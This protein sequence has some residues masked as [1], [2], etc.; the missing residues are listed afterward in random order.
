MDEQ[1]PTPS[2]PPAPD[3]H[4]GT[5]KQTLAVPIAII[6]AGAFIAVALYF[7]GAA[8]HAPTTAVQQA[9]QATQQAKSIPPVTAS[10]H[11][12]GNANAKLVIVEYTDLECP[13]CKQFHP[14]MEQVM[15]TYGK[16]GTV[17]W[18]IRN[19]PLQQ[20]HPNA[21]Q[22][23]QAA[24]CVASLGGNDTYFKFLD[25]LFAKYPAGTFADLTAL[26]A[27]AASIG[28]KQADFS[29]C[30]ASDKFKDEIQ[31]EYNDA[32]ASGGNGTPYS[33][34][35]TKDGTAVP[36]SGAQSFATMKQVIETLKTGGTP[37]TQ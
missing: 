15:S 30:V 19:F 10:D 8:N 29:A 17:A 32:I 26:P 11:I 20:L 5:P 21:P 28:I 33:V 22:V 23:A 24:E 13:F 37:V 2:M 34:I 27:L 18:V 25:A 1:S 12:M 3:M 4:P 36:V 16:D 31:K 6:I 7:S 35:L 9:A 14:T